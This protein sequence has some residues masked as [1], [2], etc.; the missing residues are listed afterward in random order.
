MAELVNPVICVDPVREM[1]DVGIR[2]KIANIQT[3]CET[4]EQ[5]SQRKIQYDKLLI[6]GTVHHFPVN[7]LRQIF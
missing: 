3:I 6:K 1:L 7:N 2:N 5:F 4:A